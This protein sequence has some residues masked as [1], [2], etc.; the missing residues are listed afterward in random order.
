MLSILRGKVDGMFG[1]I[2]ISLVHQLFRNIK[3]W[4]FTQVI[5]FECHEWQHLLCLLCACSQIIQRLQFTVVPVNVFIHKINI[6]LAPSTLHR[7]P[8]FSTSFLYKN[9]ILAFFIAFRHVF[10]FYLI[11]VTEA[12]HLTIRW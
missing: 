2:I 6:T 11:L 9:A 8:I 7:V 4:F 1:D 12:C 5:P 3:D 10:H